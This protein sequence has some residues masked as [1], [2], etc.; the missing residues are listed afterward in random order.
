MTSYIQSIPN[1]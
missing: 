1:P